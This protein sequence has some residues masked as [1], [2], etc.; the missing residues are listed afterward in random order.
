[1]FKPALAAI[2]FTSAVS[3]PACGGGG[4]GPISV[5]PPEPT[6]NE[7][8][9]S[10]LAAEAGAGV[11]SPDLRAL[12]ET[13]WDQ[14]MKASPVWASTMGDHRFDDKIADHS[15]SAILAGQ[16]QSH[17]LLERARAMDS[18]VLSAKDKVTLALFIETLHRQ[19]EREQCEN[20]R[21]S[22]S[23][24]GN[25]VSA[26]NGVADD[27]KI[28][29]LPSA[30]NLV[31]R[32]RQVPKSIDDNI[33]NL[34]SGLA[35]GR[36]ANAETV[37]RT[38]ALVQGQLDQELESWSLLAPAKSVSELEASGADAVA[39]ELYDVVSSEIKPA[40]ERYL[41]FLSE[42]L[43]PAGRAGDQIGVHALPNGL[44][45]YDASIASHINLDKGALEIHEL[46]LREIAR[47]NEEMTKLGAKLFG[48]KDLA[49]T[50]AHLRNSKELYY[51]TEEEIVEKAE[52]SLAKA[53]AAIPKFFGILPKTDCVVT[54]IPVFEAPY[55]TIAYYKQP[56]ANGEK[57]GE[58]YINTYKPETRPRFEM[59]VLAYH[60]SIPGHHL[61]IA[62]SQERGDLPL[63]RRH[64]GSTAFVEGWALYTERLA[65]EMQMYTGDLDRMGMLSYDAWRASRLVVDTGI[66]AKGWTRKQAETFMREHT[67]LTEGNIVNE[68][69]RYI[70]WPGQAV[71]YKIGQLEIFRLRAL[72]MET[73][74]DKFDIRKFHDVVLSQGAVTL[75]VL[76]TQVQAWI[77]SA[78]Q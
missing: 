66:H 8:V 56:H 29:G 24:R 57:P 46:G 27:H 9:K 75:P 68:V 42:E 12:L 3:L 78:K 73:L 25:P 58:Y 40:F 59:E 43:A 50:V 41:K 30:K 76:A 65:D 23:A 44:A 10:P 13:H 77:A 51:S 74:G 11:E 19:K 31:T 34:R 49:S 45:C 28:T 32:Y 26:A 5:P 63:F 62:I 14:E 55:T 2:L 60:E 53:K 36:V 47:I 20:Y 4:R 54:K 7:V 39:A 6:I 72:A 17:E 69:D 70:S 61:Q 52:A 37:L 64:G 16:K 22:V 67:A 15:E 35:K 71:A 33:A 38:I 21:W 48:E 18:N 1:M